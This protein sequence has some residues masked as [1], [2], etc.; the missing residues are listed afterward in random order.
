MTARTLV[1]EESYGGDFREIFRN[2]LALIGA[3]IGTVLI[4]STLGYLALMLSSASDCIPTF[5][6][7][8]VAQGRE[9][10]SDEFKSV[11]IAECDKE[12]E[13]A[14]CI[15]KMRS[16]WKKDDRSPFNLE[17]NLAVTEACPAETN[18]DE[19]DEFEIEFEP[20]ALV[21]L[22]EEIEEKEIPEK[23]IIQETRAP[24]VVEE[25]PTETITDDEKAAPAEEK[26]EKEPDPEV[27]DKPDK[28]PLE[29]KD[30]SL[31]VNKIPTKANTP[32][33][34]LPT[35]KNPKGDPFGDPDGWAEIAKDG[36][37]WATSVMKALNNMPV[38]AY[39]AKAKKGEFRFQLS[40]CKDGT[41]Q[42]VVDKGGSLPPDGVHGVMLALQQLKIPK[43]PAKIASQMKSNCA[44]I[45]YTF[46]WSSG[47]VK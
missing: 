5:E 39:A 3:A 6:K 27:K 29:P 13:D 31:P 35:V 15:D 43:P 10:Y 45:K 22:G 30:K 32:Y 21:K 19:E 12:L 46:K 33:K 23:I 1:Y 36:D 40:I 11:V 17:Y 18:A 9:L 44:K 37:P 7:S 4:S 16:D 41:I 26:E 20:G 34:D 2:P 24:D 25:K 42:K 8:W 47:G 38:G 14:A 28:K